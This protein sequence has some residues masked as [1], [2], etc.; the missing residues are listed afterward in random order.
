MA[1]TA[2]TYTAKQELASGGHCFLAANNTQTG[3]AFA[4]PNTWIAGLTN[5]V[6]ISVGMAIS[7]TN[8]TQNSNTAWFVAGIVNSTAVMTSKVSA[9]AANLGT[10]T[11]TGDTFYMGLIKTS[12][13]INW[14]GSANC[15]GYG[16]G[17]GTTAANLVGT[18]EVASG[19]GYTLGGIALTNISPAVGTTAAY[20]SFTTNP[21]WTSATF[22]TTAGFIYNN[23]ARIG[24]AGGVNQGNGRMIS[25]HDFG[26]TQTV[27]AGTFTV[28]LPTN[29]QGTSILQIS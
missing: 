12:P 21:S 22:S 13:S 19:G 23:S 1:V 7:V 27:S 16:A 20:W 15:Y 10:I 26:G 29:G 14:N 8:T 24:C 25:I 3:N 11:F 18:D 28:V 9:A 2:F 4:S 17:A 6:G 5:T